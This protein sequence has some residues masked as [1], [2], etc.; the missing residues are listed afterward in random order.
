M[1]L[2]AS[3][4]YTAVCVGAAAGALL[5]LQMSLWLPHES[6]T[7][8]WATLITNLL[9]CTL[10]GLITPSLSRQHPIWGLGVS[11]GVLGGFTTFSTFALD[12]H[13]L[14]TKAPGLALLNLLITTVGG[15]WLCLIGIRAG[16]TLFAPRPTD[17]P[18]VQTP[19]RSKA[20]QSTTVGTGT[21]PMLPKGRVGTLWDRRKP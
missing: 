19:T 20:A 16:L 7:F 1:A 18:F 17:G 5:R 15:I 4:R 2:A 14:A 6:G 3:T 11:T 12:L 13:E 9:G 8:P 21:T 10:I